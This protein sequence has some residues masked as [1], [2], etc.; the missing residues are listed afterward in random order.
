MYIAVH[1]N[2]VR[3]RPSMILSTLV[4][5]YYFLKIFTELFSLM[6]TEP[7]RPP[8]KPII[9]APK[10]AS[11]EGVLMVLPNLMMSV[12]EIRIGKMPS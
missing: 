8:V 2:A 6:K 7:S 12:F 4:F 10:S 5:R 9:I 1:V 11:R 3:M